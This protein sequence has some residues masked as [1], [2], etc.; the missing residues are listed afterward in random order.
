MAPAHPRPARRRTPVLRDYQAVVLQS[1]V[2][3]IARHRGATF[4]VLFPRQAGKNQ[5]QAELVACLLRSGAE[6]GGTVVVCAPSY[7]P[8]AEIS[9]QRVRATLAA[10]AHLFPP[11]GRAR[12]SGNRVSLG[13]ADAVYLSADRA[14][15]VAGHT[16]S[17]ALIADE[18]QDIDQEWFDR[19]FRPMAAST[20]APAIL[21]GTP[22][23]GDSLLDRAV[24]ANRA[25]DAAMR[26]HRY[27]EWFPMHHE[28]SWQRVAATLPAYGR[29]VE[30]ERA[31][32]GEHHPLFVTQYELG[33]TSDAGRL[34]APEQLARMAGG[35]PRERQPVAG[36]RYV[37]GLDIAG[38]GADRSVL[39]VARLDDDVT[40]VVDH[41]EWEH[42]PLDVVRRD[43]A[44]LMRHWRFE[45]LCVDA[46]GLGIGVAQALAVEFGP[47]VEP[48]V[49]TAG[50]KSE[51]GYS[52]L[53]AV[54]LGRVLLYE[55]DGSPESGRCR[56]ELRSC[57]AD[58]TPAR[59][60][61]WYGAAGAHDDYVASLALCV[62]AAALAGPSR[63]ATGRRR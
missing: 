26:G 53:S 50:S 19:Q 5:V 37:A 3:G 30:S 15:N 20:G 9:L 57:A 58:S 43:V 55:H 59:Q 24:A 39:S 27:R 32:L 61:R 56:A 8:Q 63:T 29:Y 60:L 51:L 62:R 52:L 48:L 45:R 18:A 16:A 49:F 34:F 42:A 41:V 54:G 40:R 22:W 33:T 21:F 2:R 13:R 11:S 4:T 1:L 10:T 46:T 17:L 12:I 36:A 25:R 6:S 23:N 38:E 7:H 14:A 31:R 35:Y 44:G 47:A 28:V